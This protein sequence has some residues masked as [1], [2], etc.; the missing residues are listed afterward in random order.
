MIRMKNRYYKQVVL[1]VLVVLS[2]LELPLLAHAQQAGDK[3]SLT[4][5]NVQAL[6]AEQHPL[7]AAG[8]LDER[9]G[10]G[11]TAEARLKRLPL[12]YGDAK[13]QRNLIIPVTPVPANAFDP[14]AP[15]GEL[16][17]LRFTTRWTSNAG[18][19]GSFD[20][21]NPQKKGAIQE[22]EIKEEI[23]RLENANTA[24][25]MMYEAGVAYLSALIAAE[26]LRLAIVDT[27][28][29][30]KILRM[31]RQQFDEGRLLLSLLN[32][33]K[34]D[35]NNALN[36]LEEAQQIYDNS[37]AQLLYAMG[38]GPEE[39]VEIEF[40]DD[41]ESLFQ[42][43]QTPFDG[44]MLNSFAYH[45]LLQNKA[46]LAAQIQT[47]RSSYLPSLTFNA[48]Y[49]A[50]YFD[51]SFGLLK[52]ANWNGNSFVNLGLRLPI[53]EGFERQKRIGRLRLQQQADQLRY[54]DERNRNRLDYLAARR[55][56]D[57]YEK[58][59]A[60]ARENF[61]LAENNLRLAE[62]QFASGRLLMGDF[63]LANYNYQ[64][65]KNNYLNVAY[66][67]I[68]SKLTMQRLGSK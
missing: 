67:F 25:E 62:E 64:R 54:E 4:L 36:N 60:R 41:L 44:D 61:L 19:N 7:M 53:S 1:K 18:I 55:E 66:H 30:S 59:Y 12:V 51:N 21:F 5:E 29:Q 58:N 65:E 28:A 34:A 45:R 16:L 26:Q 3:L 52:S 46:L 38:Y 14:S 39:D 10:Q 27:L 33:V 49:G 8:M 13:L 11:A 31:S 32:Q 50:N 35:R 47:E 23:T 68:S 37:K 9:I 57:R 20:L 40:L 48:Y 15:E 42:A 2:L 24:N 22:A 63:S 56:A 17:P 43:Y 6:A